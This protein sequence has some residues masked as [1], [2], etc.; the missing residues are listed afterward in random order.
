[1]IKNIQKVIIIIAVGFGLGKL[2][3]APGTFGSL[4]GLLLSY[5]MINNSSLIN[6]FLSFLFIIIAIFVCD[7]AEKKIGNKDDPSIVADEF[8]TIPIT[9]IGLNNFGLLPILSGFILHRFFDILK[10]YPIHKL[11]KIKGGIGIVID[12]LAAAI[13]ALG[14]NH[15]IF[16]LF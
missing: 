13:I 15:I 10:P 4:I 12:D 11:Q 5:L 3:F 6:I 14:F 16:Y 2:K 1:M 8:L 7:F 9:I